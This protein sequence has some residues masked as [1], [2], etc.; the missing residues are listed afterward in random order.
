MTKRLRDGA[1]V[2]VLGSLVGLVVAVLSLWIVLSLCQAGQ[3]N[4]FVS[5][6]GRL[7]D[8]FGGWGRGLVSFHDERTQAVADYGGPAALYASAGAVIARLRR[9][10]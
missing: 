10:E 5:W 4:G 1:V 3:D 9:R 8:V 7:A 2:F 6:V